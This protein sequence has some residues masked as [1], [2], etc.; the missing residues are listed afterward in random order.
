MTAVAAAGAG[1][2]INYTRSADG[3]TPFPAQSNTGAFFILYPGDEL[4]G[5]GLLAAQTMDVFSQE[6]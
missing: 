2:T 5:G 4:Y 1:Q 3:G 6:F